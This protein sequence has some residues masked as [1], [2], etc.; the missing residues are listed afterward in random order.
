MCKIKRS[1]NLCVIKKGHVLI[2]LRIFSQLYCG[3]NIKSSHIMGIVLVMK[4]LLNIF[5]SFGANTFL[6]VPP[7]HVVV[8]CLPRPMEGMG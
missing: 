3:N 6:V 7:I 2:N 4:Q 8:V 1:N 5:I